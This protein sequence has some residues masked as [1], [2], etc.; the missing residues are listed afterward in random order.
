MRCGLVRISRAEMDAWTTAVQTGNDCRRTVRVTVF[1]SDDGFRASPSANYVSSPVVKSSD[2]R[3]WFISQGGVSVVDPRHLPFNNLPPP[4]HIEQVIADRKT[5]DGEASANGRVSL[6]AL[7]RDLQIDYTALSL[8]APEKIPFP[9]QAR[10]ARSRLAGRRHAPAGVLHDLRPAHLPLPR[11]RPAT[12]AAC[13]TRPARRWI[14]RSR[15]R[16][17]RRRGFWRSRSA[18]VDRAGLGRPPRPPPHRREARA[19]DHRAQRAADEGAGTG[20]DSH[21]RR[22][23][24]RRHAGD[25]GGRR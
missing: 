4:V 19:G 15:R 10:R 6:P 8:V 5:Y 1:D 12:T 14:S 2:G 17:T 3:L 25:A 16:T 22:A 7:T 11:H 24:R 18:R 23:A 20:A 9:L 21:R 13:G